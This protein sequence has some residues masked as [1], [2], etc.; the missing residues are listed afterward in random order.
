MKKCDCGTEA[1]RGNYCTDCWNEREFSSAFEL[2]HEERMAIRDD[3]RD[4][5][6]ASTEL[7]RR[8]YRVRWWDG[9]SWGENNGWFP[10][11]CEVKTDKRKLLAED[12]PDHGDYW[13]DG[14]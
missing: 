8:T 5:W 9:D 14:L 1:C 7:S 10:S 6:S 12:E 4:S 3:I 13:Q 11:P 2:T